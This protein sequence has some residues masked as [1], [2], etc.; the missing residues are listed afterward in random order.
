[1][2]HNRFKKLNMAS[3]RKNHGAAMVVAIIIMGI[4]MVFAFALLLVSYT[5]Y[6]SQNKKAS[7]IRCAEAANT[8]S[9]AITDEL[10]D[11]N[12]YKI[13]AFWK[14]L[15]C[16]T[17]QGTKTWPYYE[18]G[19]AGHEKN[20][21]FRYFDLNA[22]SNYDEVQGFPGSVKLCV[23]WTVKDDSS[24]K[25]QLVTRSFEQLST[26]DRSG[27]LIHIEVIAESG[28]QTY[29]VT[30]IY[31]VSIS[32]IEASSVEGKAIKTMAKTKYP[33]S[34]SYIY[35]PLNLNTIDRTSSTDLVILPDNPIYT[36]EKWSMKL[37][38][39]E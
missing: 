6:A 23:Y 32:E 9:V 16:N 24:V 19:T 29:T 3:I 14:Y 38:S 26:N 17:L 28:S 15:R 20:D 22:N 4:I 27:A 33:E 18:P 31:E 37:K 35:N 21:A 34:E 10:E 2:K 1:M 30:N 25:S 13:S 39:R 5:L 11:E 8:F 12:A 36:T 7:N